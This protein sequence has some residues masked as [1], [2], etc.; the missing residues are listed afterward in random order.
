MS[1]EC[2]DVQPRHVALGGREFEPTTREFAAQENYEGIA[3]IFWDWSGTVPLIC[4][5]YQ[6]RL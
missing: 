1:R 4:D 2:C 3:R 5:G 6:F